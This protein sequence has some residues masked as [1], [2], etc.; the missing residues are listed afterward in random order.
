MRFGLLLLKDCDSCGS[1]ET[2][3]FTDSW[4]G[5]ELCIECLLKALP[6]VT[7]SPEEEGDNLREEL[8]LAIGEDALYCE[9]G[10]DG[11]VPHRP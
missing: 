7:M 3:L 11:A 5:L 8:R 2:R 4:T 9:E 1:S 6:S 10:F